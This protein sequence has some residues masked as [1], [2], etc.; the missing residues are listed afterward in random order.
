VT[1]Q[2]FWPWSF[3]SIA[4]LISAWWL[5][6]SGLH[7]IPQ[8]RFPD[9][10]SVLAALKQIS[11]SRYAGANIAAHVF[12]SVTLVLKG[13]LVALI[14]GLALGLLMS[15]S[16]FAYAF[17]WP[18]F[19][20]LRPIP[21]LAWVPLALLWFG[22][23]DASKVFVIALAASIP[24]IINTITGVREIDPVLIEAAR[25][26]GAKGRFFLTNVIF[27]GALPHIMIGVRLAMQTCWTV[28][29][30]AE[31]LGAIF[32]VGK[33]LSTAMDDVFPAMM[34][35]GMLTVAALG[36]LSSALIFLLE[37][38]AMQWRA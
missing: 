5:L 2:S 3:T 33:V 8:S 35:V 24:I 36:M 26:N 28:L 4:A 38:R 13:F 6:T 34:L 11:L 7:V 20:S 22:L 10:E 18:S 32:G 37:R 19:N 21:P 27:P 14:I 25:V 31:L 1:K 15:L 16:P 29:V 12:S 9:P 30:A 17:L 23:G